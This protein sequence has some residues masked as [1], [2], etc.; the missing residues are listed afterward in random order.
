[1]SASRAY[2][3]FIDDTAFSFVISLPRREARRIETA[4]VALRDNPGADADYIQSD[5]EGHRVVSKITGAYVIDYWIDEAV[6]QVNVLRVD[7]AD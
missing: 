1:M 2:K 3:L 5:S 6:K 4:L 7:A